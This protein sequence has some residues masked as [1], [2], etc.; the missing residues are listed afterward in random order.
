MPSVVVMIYFLNKKMFNL[1]ENLSFCKQFTDS[2]LLKNV[3]SKK[4]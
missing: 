2:L 1:R 4:G 3:N